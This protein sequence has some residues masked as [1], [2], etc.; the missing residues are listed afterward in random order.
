MS[1]SLRLHDGTGTIA[2]TPGV[3][4]NIQTGTA[5][6][7]NGTPGYAPGCVFIKQTASGDVLYMNSGTATS[8][9]F[10]SEESFNND[11]GTTGIK[12]DAVQEH[13]ADAGVT[14]DGVLVKDGVVGADTVNEFTTDAGVTVDG[15]LIKDGI[16]KVT[17]QTKFNASSVDEWVFIADG[18]Y[19]VSSIKELH[20]VAGTDGSGV[21]LGVRKIASATVA[22]PGAN[23]AAG[24]VEFLQSDFSLKS[25]A[26]T[27]VTGTL[28]ATG[29]D[30]QLSTGDKIGL[31][32]AGTLTTLAGGLLE[33]VLVAR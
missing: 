31:N 19:T 28:S 22:A 24:I 20:A 12:A 21:T 7:T 8:C 14:I 9:T 5:I 32:F 18:N 26:N 10:V 29:S 15:V 4:I 6:P 1:H 16:S 25:T 17:I 23:V 11:F 3:G 27:T 2:E 13:T 30:L 33:I